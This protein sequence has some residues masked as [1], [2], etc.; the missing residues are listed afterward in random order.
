MVNLKELDE[1]LERIPEWKSM[2]GAPEWIDELEARLRALETQIA[3][4]PQSKSGAGDTCP[5]CNTPSGHIY[6]IDKDTIFG[7][8]GAMMHYYECTACNRCYNRPVRES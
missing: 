5:F 2:A 3:G 1:L 7:D 8:I 6:R 4:M